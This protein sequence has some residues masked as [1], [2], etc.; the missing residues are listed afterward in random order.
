MMVQLWFVIVLRIFL[1]DI[2]HGLMA[3]KRAY[4]EI[5]KLYRKARADR[6]HEETEAKRKR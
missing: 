6:E 3:M 2:A 1:P 5:P 4:I